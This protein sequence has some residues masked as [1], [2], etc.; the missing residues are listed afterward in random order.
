MTIP[1]N[2]VL[3]T[4]DQVAEMVQF[5]KRTIQRWVSSGRFPKPIAFGDDD[6]RSRKRWLR[7]AVQAWIDKMTPVVADGA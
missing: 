2:A 4:E 5:G 1:D 7:A 6:Q 3:L